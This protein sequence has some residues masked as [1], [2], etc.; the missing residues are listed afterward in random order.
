MGEDAAGYEFS[1]SIEKAARNRGEVLGD[2][3]RIFGCGTK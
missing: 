3:L 1:G 2:D